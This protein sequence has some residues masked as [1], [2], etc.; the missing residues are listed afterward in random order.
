MN[1]R[2]ETTSDFR[3]I[4][5]KFHKEGKSLSEIAKSTAKSKS[6][7]QHIVN[8]FKKIILANT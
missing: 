8:S 6:T 4:V 2:K 7:I 1:K 5:I 3:K